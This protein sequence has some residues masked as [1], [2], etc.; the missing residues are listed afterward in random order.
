LQIAFLY[1][2]T[3]LLLA[4]ATISI[5]ALFMEIHEDPDNALSDG[6]NMI[7]LARLETVLQNILNV[8]NSLASVN[9]TPALV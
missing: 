3:D 6:L 8:K 9:S 5:D 2:Q 1:R 7:S 4:A